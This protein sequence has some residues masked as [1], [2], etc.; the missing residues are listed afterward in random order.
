MRVV[1]LDQALRD[2]AFSLLRGVRDRVAHIQRPLGHDHLL[3]RLGGDLLEDGLLSA[4][5]VF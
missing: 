5:A 2:V 4:L 1:E 3:V